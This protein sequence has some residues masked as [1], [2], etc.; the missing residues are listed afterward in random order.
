[1]KPEVY[2]FDDQD[3]VLIVREERP[4]DS[5]EL[6]SSEGVEVSIDDPR[7]SEEVPVDLSA[8]AY[9]PITTIALG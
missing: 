2:S 6:M 9:E 5:T 8:D 3:K 7:L 4:E 1:M